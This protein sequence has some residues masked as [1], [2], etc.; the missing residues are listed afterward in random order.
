MLHS[1]INYYFVNKFGAA[2]DRQKV[3]QLLETVFRAKGTIAKIKGAFKAEKKSETPELSA[4]QQEAE[5][6]MSLI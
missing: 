3:T 5:R 1:A 2:K 4:A 6:L